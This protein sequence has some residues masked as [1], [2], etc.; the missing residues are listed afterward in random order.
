MSSGGLNGNSFK[1]EWGSS[2]LI[3]SENV[4]LEIALLQIDGAALSRST[5]NT[6]VGDVKDYSQMPE[7]TIYHER[8]YLF[9]INE[10]VIWATKAGS[11]RGRRF[12]MTSS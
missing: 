9:G 10:A 4:V 5:L 6:Y 11:C 1:D 12:W 7:G 3:K 2:L 8:D